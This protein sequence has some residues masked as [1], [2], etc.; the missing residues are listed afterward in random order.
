MAPEAVVERTSCSFDCPEMLAERRPRRTRTSMCSNMRR[1]HRHSAAL[2]GT[3][4]G[5]FVAPLTAIHGLRRCE[6]QNRRSWMTG[7]E[8]ELFSRPCTTPSIAAPSGS[9]ARMFEHRDVRVR[10][11]PL[12]VRSTG[13]FRQH[14]VAE[15]G[16]PGAMVFGYFLPK[17][18]VARSPPR[19]AE[20]SPIVACLRKNLTGSGFR[21][22][23][24]PGMT[25]RRA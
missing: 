8:A 1:L 20:P 6:L 13:K 23:H 11:G 3:A 4:N 24:G 16:L 15:T 22:T 7:N 17:Q 21:A 5:A 2:L 25:I 9:K 19:R 12:G 10:A 18:K 14:E